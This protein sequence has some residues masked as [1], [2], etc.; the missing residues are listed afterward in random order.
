MKILAGSGV[1][2]MSEV[3]GLIADRRGGSELVGVQIATAGS[4]V[5]PTEG[6]IVFVVSGSFGFDGGDGYELRS[7]P[8]DDR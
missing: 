8:F 4:V 5:G 3:V 2:V 1:V 6:R 7:W